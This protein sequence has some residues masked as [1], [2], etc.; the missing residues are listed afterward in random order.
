MRQCSSREQGCYIEHKEQDGCSTHYNEYKKKHYSKYRKV[1]IVTK[2][3]TAED[4]TMDDL[5]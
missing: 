3:V 2:V 4:G 5:H 1:P